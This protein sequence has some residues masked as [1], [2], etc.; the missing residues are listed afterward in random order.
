M[1]N[2]LSLP[3]MS[4]YLWICFCGIL[5]LFLDRIRLSLQSFLEFLFMPI[6][7]LDLWKHSYMPIGRHMIL[8]RWVNPEFEDEKAVRRDVEAGTGTEEKAI[9]VD[10]DVVEKPARLRFVRLNQNNYK[11]RDCNAV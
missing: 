1:I 6:D 4:L 8:H 5:F 11:Y 3:H 2:Q 10:V 7:P 9:V